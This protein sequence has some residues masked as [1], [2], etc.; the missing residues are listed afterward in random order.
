MLCFPQ[1]A[2]SS[3]P[4]SET[5]VLP[6]DCK[7]SLRIANGLHACLPHAYEKQS[8]SNHVLPPAPQEQSFA[9]TRRRQSKQQPIQPPPR[10]SESSRFCPRVFSNFRYFSQKSALKR[11]KI[12]ALLWA[13]RARESSQ[14]Q[15]PGRAHIRATYMPWSNATISASPRSAGTEL[16]SHASQTQLP[17]PDRQESS[18]FCPRSFGQN[19]H[20]PQESALYGPKIRAPDW[21]YA[22][23][24]ELRMQAHAS[25]TQ[26]PITCPRIYTYEIQAL[27]NCPL[28]AYK[29]QESSRSYRMPSI[30]YKSSSSPT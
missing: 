13:Y 2:Q 21:T 29:Q 6:V 1:P 8:F 26:L 17:S 18:R 9:L 5:N 27:H 23:P 10:R 24:G 28:H 7:R 22:G 15:V 14:M 11:E 4:G 20:F 30:V 16:C 19:R 12:R 25:I 3:L